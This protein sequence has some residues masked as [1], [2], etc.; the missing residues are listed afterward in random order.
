MAVCYI[1]YGWVVFYYIPHYF[2]GKSPRPLCRLV[3][4]DSQAET[5]QIL[6][7]WAGAWPGLLLELGLLF[8]LCGHHSS[9]SNA[10]S[11]WWVAFGLSRWSPRPV[12]ND[13]PWL[14]ATVCSTD[15]DALRE[16]IHWDS[17]GP[18]TSWGRL[19]SATPWIPPLPQIRPTHCSGGAV[20]IA[21]GG[22]SD[23]VVGV[24]ALYGIWLCFTSWYRS[25]PPQTTSLCLLL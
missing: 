14:F 2:W 9:A 4:R 22:H 10:G 7:A 23:C 15:A 21:V 8:V 1:S 16:E 11:C 5:G 18:W 24:F 25:S 19:W 17:R 13:S 20:Q 12:G 3:Y 6:A